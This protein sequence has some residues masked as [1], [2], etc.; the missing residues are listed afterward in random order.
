MNVVLVAELT[1]RVVQEYE[2]NMKQSIG[3]FVVV[4]VNNQTSDIDT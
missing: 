4:V 1:S 2:M 3:E